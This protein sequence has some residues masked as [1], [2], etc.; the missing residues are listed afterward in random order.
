LWLFA[1]ATTLVLLLPAFLMPA[2]RKFFQTKFPEQAAA[3]ANNGSFSLLD[4]FHMAEDQYT[5]AARIQHAG[6]HALPGDPYIRENKSARLTVRDFLT[7]YAL[8]WSYRFTGDM[9]QAWLLMHLGLTLLWVPILFSLARRMGASEE[10]ALFIA[11][12]ST[13]FN[14]LTRL[15]HG[16]NPVQIAKD[17][18][19]YAFWLLGSYHYW[20][21]PTRLLRPLFT[22]PCLFGAALALLAADRGRT[23]GRLVLAGLAGAALAY[24]HPDV[25]VAYVGASGLYVSW[26][27]AKEK[28]RALPLVGALAVTGLAS[29]PS[30]YYNLSLHSELAVLGRVVG[31]TPEWASF[32][33]VA[34]VASCWTLLKANGAAR[35]AAGGITTSFLAMNSQLVIG[36]SSDHSLWFYLANT[37]T[38]IL[39][40]ARWLPEL[41]LAPVSWVW[42]SACAVLLALPRAISY[43]AHHYKIYALPQPEEDAYRWLKANTEQDAVVAAL[44]PTTNFRLPVHTENKTLVARQFP[45]LSDI[46]TQ[47]NAERL[48]YGLSLFGAAPGRFVDE[49]LDRSGQ[50]ERKLWSGEVDRASRERSLAVL[51]YFDIIDEKGLRELLAAPAPAD[52]AARFAPDYLWYGPF[53]KTLAPKLPAAAKKAGWQPVFANA[54][55]TIFRIR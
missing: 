42:L 55:T 41:K 31:R 18:V 50:W 7:F 30:V 23:A 35:W 51:G 9:P 36:Y 11:V 17:A 10:L 52:G 40:A 12:V 25:W 24:V 2:Q 14:D 16:T 6:S 43:S 21:G 46:S 26:A 22:Y 34:A 53:E 49:T 20:P 13:L 32:L 44:S 27:L 19:Q 33:Y 5:Y 45:I 3:W 48:R 15:L 28:S 4:S 29:L 39:L 38:A 1:A 37:L 8:G 47:E 54:E